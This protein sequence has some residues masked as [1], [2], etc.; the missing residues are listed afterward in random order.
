MRTQRSPAGKALWFIETHFKQDL[1]LGE[2][3]E[4][5][6][7]SRY[8]MARAFESATG[9]S[10]MRY[11]RGRRLSEAARA[12]AQGA[13]EILAVA[14]EAG[15]G[16]HEAFTRAFREQFGVTPEAVRAQGCLDQL[17]LLEP[18]KMNE[19]TLIDLEEP[20]F[21]EG[22]AFLMA[23]IAERYPCDDCAAIPAQWQRFT[24]Y[25]GTIKGQIGRVSYGVGFNGDGQGNFDYMCAVEVS[26]DAELP[27]GFTRLEIKP[28]KYAV[29]T[30]RGHIST[31]ANTWNTIWNKWLPQSGYEYA[32]A[33]NMERVG[34]DFNGETGLGS[35][36]IWI[37]IKR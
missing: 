24:P 9:L 15:Y 18:R 12:L 31:I 35:L 32:L 27:D 10:V 14:V 21:E 3:A 19:A 1:T 4:Y 34:E 20:R 16:S 33:P 8:H 26:E 30:H 22:R 2:I 36:E 17:D 28:Q 11:V 29:F 25:L 6:G 7:V 23:G 13:P 5:S 37:P